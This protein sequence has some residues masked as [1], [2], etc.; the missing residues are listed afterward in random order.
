MAEIQAR[1]DAAEAEVLSLTTRR[2]Q[3]GPRDHGCHRQALGR[4][5]AAL[6]AA[7]KEVSTTGTE[8][9]RRRPPRHGAVAA[10]D[11]PRQPSPTRQRRWTQAAR[12][13]LE[14]VTGAGRRGAR[15]AVKRAATKVDK[16]QGK[17]YAPAFTAWQM[18]A[19]ADRVGQA[20]VALAKQQASEAARLSHGCR[21]G[22]VRCHR[23]LAPKPMIGWPG[24]AA[25]PRRPR[26]ASPQPGRSGPR[27]GSSSRPS[28]RSG[29]ASARHWPGRRRRSP[30]S[31]PSWRC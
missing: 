1:L 2:S 5:S 27:P 4:H 23:P 11:A 31:A 7:A 26:S 3:V 17:A 20:R 9:R 16:A 10:H 25:R 14:D 28:G 13:R 29:P 22:A 6:K 18:A 12:S 30:G 21:H 8:V 24:P 19:I 15:T